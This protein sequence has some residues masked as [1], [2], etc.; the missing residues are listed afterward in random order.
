MPRGQGT[1][2][3][4]AVQKHKQRLLL[5]KQFLNLNVKIRQH[6]NVR[7]VLGK[8]KGALRMLWAKEHAEV[9]VPWLSQ[10]RWMI[11]RHQTWRIYLKE[12]S[13]VILRIFTDSLFPAWS[14]RQTLL[15]SSLHFGS[16]VSLWSSGSN[17]RGRARTG[18]AEPWNW[19]LVGCSW[20]GSSGRR[21]N[22][23][24]YNESN[25][26]GKYFCSI[27]FQMNLKGG[28]IALLK[29]KKRE[30][31]CVTEDTT[32]CRKKKLSG[33]WLKKKSCWYCIGKMEIIRGHLI[34]WPEILEA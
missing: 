14:A 11:H 4:R 19:Q 1:I 18:D 20:Y 2:M 9:Q 23:Q 10:H 6:V 28:E 21:K 33:A 22:T 3:L 16:W 29:A 24:N 13:I 17:L 27:T 31:S 8:H 26:R 15:F 30:Q 7:N 32:W 25:E 34:V 5:H 12:G